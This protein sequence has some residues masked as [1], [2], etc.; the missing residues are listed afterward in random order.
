VVQSQQKWVSVR[1]LTISNYFP[2]AYV[3]GAETAAYMTCRG[4]ERRGVDVHVLFIN[5]R[6][7]ETNCYYDWDGLRVHQVTFSTPRRTSLTDIFDW[8]VYWAT[9]EEIRRVRPDVV[10]IHNVSGTSLAPFVACRMSNT[11]VVSTLHDS[12]LLCPNNMLYRTGGAFCDPA[13][14]PHRCAECFRRYDF[15]GDMPWRRRILAGLVNRVHT[16]ISPSQALVDLHVRGGYDRHRFQVIKNGIQVPFPAKLKHPGVWKVLN[17]EARYTTLLYAGGG[18]EIKGI[19][20]LLSALPMLMRYV[21]PLRVVVAGGGEKHYFDKLRRYA[22][23]IRLLGLVHYTDMPA[24]YAAADLSLAISVC[25]ENS[26][27][28]IQ[29]SLCMGTPVVGSSVGGIPELLRDGETGY[30]VPPRDPT[31]LVEQVMLHFARSP[32]E[33]RQ[34]RQRCAAYATEYFD[35]E[36]HL[37]AVSDVYRQAIEQA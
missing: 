31:A 36:R 27:V 17:E 29:Q 8:R 32:R 18:I 26:P 21:E 15:W 16:F 22:P 6:M 10:H 12:W 11:P 13:Q 20:T 24:L 5:A 23:A 4:L 14:S 28:V 30:L 25:L 33:R 34:M 37:D 7:P 3:G 19:E 35:Y 1:V 2:P 9:I